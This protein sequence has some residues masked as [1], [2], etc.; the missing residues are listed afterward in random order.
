MKIPWRACRVVLHRQKKRLRSEQRKANEKSWRR[1][2]THVRLSA[3]RPLGPIEL[4]N[5]HGH[6]TAN[7]PG[8][9][10]HNRP[11]DSQPCTRRPKLPRSTKDFCRSKW[12]RRKYGKTMVDPKL[13]RV[14]F[15]RL[16]QVVF[17]SKLPPWRTRTRAVG[18]P[19]T[20]RKTE[21]FWENICDRTV[22]KAGECDRELLARR[23]VTSGEPTTV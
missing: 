16:R 11:K 23:W 3:D 8:K 19:C 14:N 6:A 17:K 5:G 13:D 22:C 18:A 21:R 2:A 15:D 4:T 7:I 20:V 10:C 9:M 1:Q 12:T